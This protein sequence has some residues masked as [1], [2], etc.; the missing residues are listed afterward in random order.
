MGTPLE[1]MQETYRK[2][3]DRQIGDAAAAMRRAEAQY[4]A[5]QE[6]LDGQYKARRLTAEEYQVKSNRLKDAARAAVYEASKT[7]AGAIKSRMTDSDSRAADRYARDAWLPERLHQDRVN[8]FAEQFERAIRAARTGQEV[9]AIV[10]GARNSG[11]R[12]QAYAIWRL[13]PE[14]GRHPHPE[15]RLLAG[16]AEA[17]LS[18]HLRTHDAAYA[19]A[20]EVQN[21]AHRAIAEGIGELR[22]F[23][24]HSPYGGSQS[25]NVFSGGR[26][27]PDTVAHVADLF[28]LTE[29][30]AAYW[31]PDSLILGRDTT[32]TAPSITVKHHTP[33]GPNVLIVPHLGQEGGS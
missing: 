30:G 8:V 14:L 13:A 5:Q 17:A 18:H 3:K 4:R 1:N 27:T 11:D 20:V 23:A 32:N 16:R 31:E 24:A 21:S 6:A 25:A 29:Q 33:E 28:A 9:E 22:S 19:E 12:D 10:E 7:L 26:S 2:A 15:K